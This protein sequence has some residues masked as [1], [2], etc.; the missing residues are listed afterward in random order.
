M[1]KCVDDTTDHW[2]PDDLQ[3]FY[4]LRAS[5][6]LRE[7]ASGEKFIVSAIFTDTSR[8]NKS[9]TKAYRRSGYNSKHFLPQNSDLPWDGAWWNCNSD[10]R[11]ARG[12][13]LE[14]SCLPFLSPEKLTNFRLHNNLLNFRRSDL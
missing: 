6:F 4:S 8:T 12:S 9:V 10:A 3:H 5:F 7:S 1:R 13:Y 11:R 2:S 14:N